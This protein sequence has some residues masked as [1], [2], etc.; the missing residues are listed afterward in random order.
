M[1]TPDA[2]R[3]SALLDQ[4]YECI[5]QPHDWEAVI[6]QIRFE[7]GLMSGVLGIYEARSGV[8][9]LR[10]Q[11]GM[12]GVWFDKMPEYGAEMASLWGGHA[13]I[14]G[15]PIG[16]LAIHSTAVPEFDPVSNRFALEWCE[17]QKILDLAAMILAND[18]NCLSTLVFCSD[19]QLEK[20]HPGELDLLRILSP[21]LCRAVL[22][23]RLLDIKSFQLNRF[24]SALDAL[25]NGIFLLDAKAQVVHANAAAAAVV[26][27]N[28]GIRVVGGRL[29]M[30][31]NFAEKALVAALAMCELG[32]SLSERGSAIP[33]VGSTGNRA[34]LHI[35]PLRYGSFHDHLD[36]R[37][38]AAIF[39]TTELSDA[40]LPQDSTAIALRSHACRSAGLRTSGR[41]LSSRR[42][43]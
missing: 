18:G 27:S 7:L 22:I 35:L 33:A 29:T 12:D 6:A 11:D 26:R 14:A 1:S 19:R 21:H 3:V 42:N 32:D 17:P 25:P 24:Q 36:S 20:L 15:Y 30:R 8:P 43:C 2:Q 4:I 31:D 28:D 34:L 40:M 38:T 41:R 10:I 39:I 16:E 13:R 9:Q 37:A 5:L 23:S